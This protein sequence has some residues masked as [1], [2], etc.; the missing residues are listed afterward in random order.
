M[1]SKLK[2]LKVVD[3]KDV[4]TRAGVSIPTK[5]NKPDLIAKIIAS[6]AALSVFDEIHGSGVKAPGVSTPRPVAAPAAPA[7]VEMQTKVKETENATGDDPLVRVQPENA[8]KPPS[9]TSS[10]KSKP[11][12]AAPTIVSTTSVKTPK[13]TTTLSNPA[14][15]SP[16]AAQSAPQE[17]A[18]AAA[19]TEDEETARRRARAERFGIPFVAPK[20]TSTQTKAAKPTA[21]KAAAAAKT[22]VNGA[23]GRKAAAKPVVNVDPETLNAR[24]QRFGLDVKTNAKASPNAPAAVAVTGQKRAAPAEELDPEEVER[25]RKRAERF[26]IKA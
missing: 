2:A 7:K 25:R 11:A 6:P 23:G 10:A 22:A 20:K 21:P 3:L 16:A 17:E 12:S 4:L 19:I 18:P 8:V 5:A 15:V 14:S 9:T 24:A 13:S 1:E 26:G